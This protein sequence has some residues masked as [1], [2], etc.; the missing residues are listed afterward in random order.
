MDG[1]NSP[2]TKPSTEPIPYLMSKEGIYLDDIAGRQ[3]EIDPEIAA[4]YLYGHNFA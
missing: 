2:P 4:L 1:A 3:D